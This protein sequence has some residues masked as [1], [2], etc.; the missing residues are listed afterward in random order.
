MVKKLPMIIINPIPGQEAKNT[1]YLLTHNVAV[2]AEKAAGVINYID[3][4]LRNPEKL[5]KMSEAAAALGRPN[6]A[7]DAAQ[8]ILN[9]LSPTTSP[10]LANVQ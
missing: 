9:L 3:G 4:F 10:T 6:A 8:D 7:R 2:Q 5:R 1:D